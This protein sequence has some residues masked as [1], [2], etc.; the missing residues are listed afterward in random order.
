MSL[1]WLREDVVDKVLSEIGWSQGVPSRA[2]E[3][4]NSTRACSNMDATSLV[5]F[6]NMRG[7]CCV[8]T[9]D[10]SFGDKNVLLMCGEV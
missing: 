5:I 6:P 2:R 10:H 8:L 7:G 1:S 9:V 4:F 3:G